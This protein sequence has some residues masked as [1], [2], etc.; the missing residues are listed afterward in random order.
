MNN[1]ESLQ[2]ELEVIEQNSISKFSFKN[3]KTLIKIIRVIDGDSVVAIFK[4]NNQF[5]KYNFRINGIDTPETNSK[6]EYEKKKGIDTKIYVQNLLIN[7]ILFA[8]FLDF[9]KYGRI[10]LN[11]YLNSNENISEHLING[12]YAN[13]YDGR[14]KSSWI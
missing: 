11:L 13:K 9:D 7:K 14:G 10:L 2:K 8:E 4:F 12:G 1:L 5:Y 6:N 3:Y